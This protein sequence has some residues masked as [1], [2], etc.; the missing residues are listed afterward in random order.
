M[1]HYNAETSLLKVY[2]D[3]HSITDAVSLVLQISLDI[4]VAFDSNKHSV[5]LERLPD[6]FGIGG[7]ALSRIESFLSRRTQSLCVGGESSSIII[8]TCGVPQGSVLSPALFANYN[9]PL[10]VVIARH[11]AL[12]STA[13]GCTL[14]CKGHNIALWNN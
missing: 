1:Q 8:C 4:S 10:P 3:L 12:H 11:G 2:E 13:R 6:D 9:S 14:H 5:P 7:K